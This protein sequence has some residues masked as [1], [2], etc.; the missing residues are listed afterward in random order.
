MPR[1][2]LLILLLFFCLL[3][4]L[5]SWANSAMQLETFNLRNRPA[6]DLLPLV[7]PFLDPEGAIRGQGYKLFVKSTG[8]N[9]EQISQIIGEL[10]VAL[11]RLRISISTD[12]RNF[13]KLEKQQLQTHPEATQ[14]SDSPNVQK[15]IISKGPQHK[16]TT[17][18][19][20]TA[21]RGRQPTAQQVQLLEGQWASINSGRAIPIADRQR[22]A[23]GT[24]T[25][26]IRYRKLSYGFKVR[27][28][29][30]GNKVYLILRPKYEE[31]GS[32]GGGNIRTQN[33]DTSL[34]VN[35][36]QWT[37]IGGTQQLQKKS[38]S[39]IYYRTQRKQAGEQRMFIKVELLE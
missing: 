24:V 39:G 23:D 32:Q 12:A 7:K 16:L 25:E 35:L 13:D 27:A 15:I 4:S 19:Y 11:K 22:N 6:V 20:S 2:L 14:N 5:P 28:H 31:L 30:N 38:A 26:T 18:V 33:I 3:P 21:Q 8:A 29:V 17:R 37:E 36:G 9:L 34:I 1:P 10:D